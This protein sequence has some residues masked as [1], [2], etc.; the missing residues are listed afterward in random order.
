MPI[1][2]LLGAKQSTQSSSSSTSIAFR[3]S[4]LRTMA[5]VEMALRQ[6][7]DRPRGLILDAVGRDVRLVA[8]QYR[9]EG[10]VLASRP[11]R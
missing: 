4:S 10:I 6:P 9:Q 8:I 5:R 2:R 11:Q 7:H 3:S 1:L